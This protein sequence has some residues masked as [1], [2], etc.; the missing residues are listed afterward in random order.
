MLAA[1]SGPQGSWGPLGGRPADR[2][3][4]TI[5][6]SSPSDP[7]GPRSADLRSARGRSTL[8]PERNPMVNQVKKIVICET[9]KKR[10]A[11]IWYL[12]LYLVGLRCRTISPRP[13]RVPLADS[14]ACDPAG[15][16]D[17]PP[18]TSARSPARDMS[19]PRE[20]CDTIGRVRRSQSHRRAVSGGGS[21]GHVPGEYI[22]SKQFSPYGDRIWRH[23]CRPASV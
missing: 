10:T 1:I 12:L 18:S 15:P 2:A 9:L 22:P 3:V 4:V 11:P 20:V 19:D 17:S 13:S 23:P 16:S 21:P 6:A 14:A 5:S 7:V 8:L